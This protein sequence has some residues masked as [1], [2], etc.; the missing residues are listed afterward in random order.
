MDFSGKY[1]FIRHDPDKFMDKYDVSKNPMFDTRMEVLEK[2]ID[3]HL[4]KIKKKFNKEFV[5]IHHLF[6]DEIT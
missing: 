5:E 6:Y 3:K 2:S 4:E 1:I